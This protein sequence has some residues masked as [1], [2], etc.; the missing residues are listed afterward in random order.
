MWADAQRDGRPAEYGWRPLLNA[1]KLGS[2]PLLECCAVT[3]QIWENARLGQKVNFAPGK[4]PL[5]GK[6]PRKC[7]YSV[8][9]QE[10]AKH[11]ANL[12]NLSA[13][14]AVVEVVE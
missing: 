7:I 12:V 13:V 6:S 1:T 9:A 2:C 14:G 4:I 3:L 8:P 11:R 10:T 5:G